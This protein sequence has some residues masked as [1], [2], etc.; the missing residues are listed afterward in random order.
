MPDWR[1]EERKRDRDTIISIQ[2][3]R[4]TSQNNSNEL[5]LRSSD[6]FGIHETRKISEQTIHNLQP[7]H[8]TRPLRR[9]NRTGRT[10]R[11]RTNPPLLSQVELFTNDGPFQQG[12]DEAPR[13]PI[14][15]P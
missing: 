5:V 10:P 2:F 8:P 3:E 12:R 11:R 4:I 15:V 9:R 7:H 13:P 6:G 1:S 14:T